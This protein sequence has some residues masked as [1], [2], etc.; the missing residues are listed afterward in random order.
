MEKKSQQYHYEKIGQLK[1]NLKLKR[2]DI[3]VD[4]LGLLPLT[5]YA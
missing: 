5:V 1:I 4:S 2:E 3:K